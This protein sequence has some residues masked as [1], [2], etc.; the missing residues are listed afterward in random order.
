MIVEYLTSS[1][2]GKDFDNKN[3]ECV[4]SRYLALF[5][6]LIHFFCS[7]NILFSANAIAFPHI[8]QQN[9]MYCKHILLYNIFSEYLYKT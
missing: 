3:N 4:G 8:S 2:I 6:N 7:N 1:L 5:S 9:D